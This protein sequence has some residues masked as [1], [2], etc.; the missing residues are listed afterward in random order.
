MVGKARTIKSEDLGKGTDS[1]I[2]RGLQNG[3]SRKEGVF[4]VV[5]ICKVSLSGK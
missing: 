5:S 3:N 4:N 2:K 1:F